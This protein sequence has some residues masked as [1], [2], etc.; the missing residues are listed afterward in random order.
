MSSSIACFNVKIEYVLSS[1]SSV[2]INNFWK[3]T[4]LYFGS[5]SVFE[6]EVARNYSYKQQTTY[7]L[8]LNCTYNYNNYINRFVL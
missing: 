2:K 5:K 4:D 3:K 7:F 6:S 8:V 1:M